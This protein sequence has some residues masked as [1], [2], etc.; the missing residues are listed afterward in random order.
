MRDK[1]RSVP[2]FYKLLG[3][4][5]VLVVSFAISMVLGA[6][7]ITLYDLW[8]A[9]TSPGASSENV[10]I[11][12]EIR[13]PRELAAMLVGAA[14]AV[15]GS[16]MQGVTRNPL[17]DPGLLGLTSGA[18]MALAVA[19]AFLPGVGY[20]GIMLA[21][22]IGSALGAGLVLGLGSMRQGKLSPIRIVLAGA[23]ISAFLYA[24]ADGISIVF[25]I[26][27]DVSMWT[28][29]GLI[30]TTWA[31][32]QV[33]TPV[34]VIAIVVAIMYSNHLTILSLSDEIAMGLGQKLVRVK[35]ILF[36][37]VVLLTGAAVA[38][39][40]NIAFLGLMIPHIVRMIVGT[41][42]RYILP[43]SVFAGASFMLLADTLGRTINA[44]YETPMAAIVAMVG[45][46]FFLF[47]VR[48]G[49]KALS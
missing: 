47:V 49:G 10:L 39:V 35:F 15:S 13:M 3:S 48:K 27:K 17:A 31:Q 9:L 22:F 19:F 42:Y 7:E 14:F 26:S 18:N 34:I 44:P 12:R 8:L 36:T 5:L 37:L 41:D 32:L 16:I 43:F 24:I 30:G 4:V 28:A 21:C 1:K 38:L 11:L 29:G 2:F 40:G 20:F 46:P 33:I 45:L 25:K 23:A 6:K